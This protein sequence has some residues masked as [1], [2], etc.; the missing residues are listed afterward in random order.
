MN[1]VHSKGKKKNKTQADD[2]V[3]KILDFTQLTPTAT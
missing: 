1:D 2:R 3:V